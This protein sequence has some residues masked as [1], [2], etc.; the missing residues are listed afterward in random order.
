MRVFSIVLLVVLPLLITSCSREE[1]AVERVEMQMPDLGLANETDWEMANKILQYVN[2]FRT[3]MGLEPL[4]ME[5]T[6][7]T[8]LAVSHSKYMA[9]KET[10]SHDNFSE[11]AAIL[12][13]EGAQAVA[14]NV[15]FGYDDAEEVVNAWI[16]SPSHRDTL[17]GSYTHVGIGIQED[18]FNSS[19]KYYTFLTTRQ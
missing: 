15:A 6:T 13:S 5:T 4:I 1:M 7:S 9:E 16:N 14:E 2:I 3:D 12:G 18:K 19:I 17:E 11:R 8:A 10:I